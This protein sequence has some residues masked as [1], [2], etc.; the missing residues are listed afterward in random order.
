MRFSS[1]NIYQWRGTEV[2]EPS[3]E[4]LRVSVAGLRT[5]GQCFRVWSG[6]EVTSVTWALSRLPIFCSVLDTLTHPA[7][8]DVVS[9]AA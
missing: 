9:R 5:T 3:P 1:R 8:A 4:Q 6:A 2:T 7:E